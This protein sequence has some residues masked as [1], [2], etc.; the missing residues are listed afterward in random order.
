[1]RVYI[2][3]KTPTLVDSNS[4]ELSFLFRKKTG[5]NDE[6][7]KKWTSRRRGNGKSKYLCCVLFRKHF[8]VYRHI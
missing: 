1:M 6:V 2:C 7:V 8:T 5:D 3:N 4:Q